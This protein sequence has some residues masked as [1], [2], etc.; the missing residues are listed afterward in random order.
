MN[1]QQKQSII[2]SVTGF[3][4]IWDVATKSFLVHT[5]R[6]IINEN[7]FKGLEQRGLKVERVIVND[8]GNLNLQVKEA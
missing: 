2:E 1:K 6:R 8:L 3:G 7:I 4:A 5:T